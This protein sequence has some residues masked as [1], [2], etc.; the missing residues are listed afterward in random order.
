MKKILSKFQKIEIIYVMKFSLYFKLCYRDYKKIRLISY[1][2]Y[3][4][5]KSSDVAFTS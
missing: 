2:S 3:G 1:T 4:Y 5:W